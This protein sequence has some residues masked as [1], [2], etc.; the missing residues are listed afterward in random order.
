MPQDPWMIDVP[1]YVPRDVALLI[2]RHAWADP[3]P[4]RADWDDAMRNTWSSTK[5]EAIADWQASELSRR[6][7][8][9]GCCI[10]YVVFTWVVSLVVILVFVGEAL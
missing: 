6:E 10:C 9:S 8:R 5:Y 3:Q 4:T 7:R 2:Q 1:S